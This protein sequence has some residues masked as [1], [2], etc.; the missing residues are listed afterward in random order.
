ME[1]TRG[2]DFS[3]VIK[4]EEVGLDPSNVERSQPS[5][6]KYLKRLLK[7]INVR[8]NDSII[9]IGSGKGSAMRIM[10]KF[11][12]E[13][14]DGIELSKHIAEIA[15]RNLKKLNAD[16]SKVFNCDA[17]IFQYYNKYNM[18]YF[19]NP[20]PAKVMYNVISKINQAIQGLDREILIIYNNP[21][22]HDIILSQGTFYKVK[23][24]PDEWDKQIYIYSNKSQKYSRLNR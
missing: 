2:I 11:P 5:G 18:F 19:F 7:D 22:C 15:K 6:N 4:P 16:R 20:F 3:A 1:K 23:E 9:D 14:V 17:T 12:F 8:D 24:Y 13:K 10:L 21:V